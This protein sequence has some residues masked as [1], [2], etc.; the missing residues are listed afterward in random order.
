M[1]RSIELTLDGIL[2]LNEIIRSF[3]PSIFDLD[4]LIEKRKQMNNVHL[5]S[6]ATQIIN[7]RKVNADDDVT[8]Y[9]INEQFQSERRFAK[10]SFLSLVAWL[11]AICINN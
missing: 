3:F 1:L 9:L 11:Y 2:L 4:I 5:E 8:M 10:E 6:V 7:K